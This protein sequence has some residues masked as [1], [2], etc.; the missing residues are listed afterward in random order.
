MTIVRGLYRVD[1]TLR[2]IALFD[3]ISMLLNYK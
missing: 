2:F 1:A 3:L